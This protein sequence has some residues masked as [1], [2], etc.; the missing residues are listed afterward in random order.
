[1]K[2][3]L[4]HRRKIVKRK[5]SLRL[6]SKLVL[7]V[8]VLVLFAVCIEKGLAVL[9]PEEAALTSGDNR[10]L[11]IGIEAYRGWMNLKNSRENAR[12]FK[13]LLVSHY[14]FEE[15][16]ITFLTDDTPRKPTL[17]EITQ[18]LKRMAEGTKSN[19]NLLVYFSGHGATDPITRRGYW[20][21]ID[22][23]SGDPDTWVPHTAVVDTLASPSVAARDVCI[24]ADSN[25]SAG[26]LSPWT[27]ELSMGDFKYR[28][29]IVERGGQPS[30]QVIAFGEMGPRER[31]RWKGL[32][33]QYLL[34]ALK[35][36]KFK[37]MDPQS[38]FFEKVTIPLEGMAGVKTTRGRIRT[39]ADKGGELVL[40]RTA[41]LPPVNISEVT[42]NPGRGYVGKSF[43]FRARTDAGASEVN[44]TIDDETY[45]M[46]GSGVQWSG[47]VPIKTK[48]K[49]TYTVT[50]INYDGVKGAGRSGTFM[51][52]ESPTLPVDIASASVDPG[53]GDVGKPFLFTATTDS[54]A[55]EVYLDIAGNRQLMRNISDFEWELEQKVD[56]VGTHEYIVVAT[57]KDDMEG[58][59]L[60]GEFDAIMDI[61]PENRF[62]DNGDGTITDR[63]SDLMWIKTGRSK[64]RGITWED[65]MAYCETLEYAG[66][67]G[68][69]LP[70]EEEWREMIDTR[71]RSP[72]LPEPNPFANVVTFA[73]YWSKTDYVAGP[74]YA[75]AVNLYYGKRK[76]L[77]KKKYAFVWP[78]RYVGGLVE[79]TE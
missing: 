47:I 58:D 19:D 35:A 62:V 64:W 55:N 51:V 60:S 15:R 8:F 61:T 46:D 4:Q 70:T 7:L 78:V 9:K 50:A 39:P 63:K 49:K 45:R 1:M 68:W 40:L 36:N 3:N 48:G 32:F 44:I 41:E 53:E 67:T 79:E 77:N 27:S 33:T 6:F 30:R 34:K 71:Y 52:V 66:R 20:V 28:P 73:E 25:F 10:A 74:G 17:A 21:P 54:Q 14:G 5:Y 65:A 13:D 72:A 37:L 43:V 56:K 38:L 22:G 18:A 75:W 59:L 26:L 24:I 57:N 11:V 29:W 23:V 16:N 12:A 69:R 2:G 31:A 42:V 76:F